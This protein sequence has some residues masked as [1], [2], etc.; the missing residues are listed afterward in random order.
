MTTDQT[1]AE[2]HEITAPYDDLRGDSLALHTDA[3][4]RL[5]GTQCRRCGFNM[6]GSRRFCSACMS[7]EL[8]EV[9]FG[10]YGTLYAFTVLHVSAVFSEPQAMGYVDLPAG[11]RVLA[12]LGEDVA[13]LRSGLPVE[14]TIDDDWRFVARKEE[15]TDV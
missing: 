1:S 8:A 15:R 10:P 14:L 9:Q 2:P 12:L 3:G 6:L 11:P 13:D 7:D 5:R 4:P